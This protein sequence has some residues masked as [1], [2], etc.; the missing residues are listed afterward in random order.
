MISYVSIKPFLQVVFAL[1]VLTFELCLL[2]NLGS[3]VVSVEAK[4]SAPG[5]EPFGPDGLYRGRNGTWGKAG[6]T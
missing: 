4:I 3:R 2:S 6:R 1:Y 5:M